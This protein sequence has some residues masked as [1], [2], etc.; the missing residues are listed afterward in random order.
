ME[1]DIRQKTK[2]VR[3]NLA[4]LLKATI[5]GGDGH[6]AVPGHEAAR[7]EIC[8]ADALTSD[9]SEFLAISTGPRHERPRSSKP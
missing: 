3:R 2:R 1:S 5:D 6:R 8:D 9:V 7:H 4:L